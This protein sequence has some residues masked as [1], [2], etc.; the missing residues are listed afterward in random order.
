MN[1][2][3]RNCHVT[4]LSYRQHYVQGFWRR[5][6]SERDSSLDDIPV[7]HTSVWLHIPERGRW[8]EN[9]FVK[10]LK[11]HEWVGWEQLCLRPHQERSLLYAHLQH[12]RED[13]G[14]NFLTV[15]YKL[16]STE[17]QL[18]KCTKLNKIDRNTSAGPLKHTIA[19]QNSTIYLF[20]NC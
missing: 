5:T 18:R 11:C 4:L 13:F 8:V 16:S 10:V 20:V 14:R 15:G 2:N 17:P 3:S 7:C 6:I 12:E 1:L 19:T 9:R